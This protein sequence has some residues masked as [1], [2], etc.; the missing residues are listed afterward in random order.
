MLS[1][2]LLEFWICMCHGLSSLRVSVTTL[3]SVGFIS[4]ISMILD[5]SVMQQCYDEVEREGNVTCHTVPLIFLG[6]SGVGK[7][8]LS[9]TLRDSPPPKASGPPKTIAL[10]E[11]RVEVSYVDMKW[12][13]NVGYF[14]EY[15]KGGEYMRALLYSVAATIS[16]MTA[17][18]KDTFKS[19]HLKITL[20]QMLL[21][22]C[23]L[24]SISY[25]KLSPRFIVLLILCT[26]FY[27]L[28]NPSHKIYFVL[29]YGTTFTILLSHFIL[30][31]AH[32]A[33]STLQESLVFLLKVLVYIFYCT[34]LLGLGMGSGLSLAFCF[35]S[36]D[37][38]AK[39][40]EPFVY[41]LFFV[42][43]SHSATLV[44][45]AKM[46]RSI[47]HVLVVCVT[48]LFMTRIY[49][50]IFYCSLGFIVGYF[51]IIFM[52]YGRIL[53]PWMGSGVSRS[54][55]ATTAIGF[56][57]GCPLA[58]LL[59][60][61]LTMDAW[62]FGSSLGGVAFVIFMLS[63]YYKKVRSQAQQVK[64]LQ[65]LLD[66]SA[67]PRK[68]ARIA[69][70]DFAGDEAYREPQKIYMTTFAL[71]IIVFKATDIDRDSTGRNSAIY[72]NICS[73]LNSISSLN[74]QQTKVY[75]VATHKATHFCPIEERVRRIKRLEKRLIRNYKQMLMH[76]PIS[77]G[78]RTRWI[79]QIEN[80]KRQE[81]D[82]DLH[83]LKQ[84]IVDN[85]STENKPLVWFH[86]LDIIRSKD[87]NQ[88]LDSVI[89]PF[90]QLYEHVSRK[91][92][93]RNK[94]EFTEMLQ[95]FSNCGEI[96]YDKRDAALSS[97][98][99]LDRSIL[100]N[101]IRRLIV[102]DPFIE[103]TKLKQCLGDL[104]PN[105][106]YS[107]VVRF[108]EC[109]NFISRMDGA[110]R[111]CYMIPFNLRKK[112][113]SDV[114]STP[115]NLV[116][117]AEF[118]FNAPYHPTSFFLRILCLCQRLETR[119]AES[120]STEFSSRSQ[121]LHSNFGRFIH[122][123]LRYSIVLHR[124]ILVRIWSDEHSVTSTRMQHAATL[125]HQLRCL[126]HHV[127]TFH[128]ENLP[129]SLRL[130]CLQCKRAHTFPPPSPNRFR[131][132]HSR[133]CGC[134]SFLLPSAEEPSL[135]ELQLS[136]NC[137]SFQFASDAHFLRHEST[138]FPIEASVKRQLQQGRR[139]PL[140]VT[141][142]GCGLSDEEKLT[143][144]R[145]VFVL[146]TPGMADGCPKC[147]LRIEKVWKRYAQSTEKCDVT[148]IPVLMAPGLRVP[149]L[150]RNLN[151]VQ[152]ETDDGRM[153][154]NLRRTLTKMRKS[155]AKM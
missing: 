109:L 98:I 150:L 137:V 100:V 67:S 16:G 111:S 81:N 132:L 75:L 18:R 136:H 66:S 21:Y 53:S 42:L 82:E 138:A 114:E 83:L 64:P 17:R 34:M 56:L 152:L 80:L 146:L 20:L 121:Q 11:T 30:T 37:N 33:S 88:K 143:E 145:G 151:P 77:D 120:L 26:G 97:F 5:D 29:A 46:P 23:I 2:K 28:I 47:S 4:D 12:R 41:V 15:L 130:F 43:S 155:W 90:D 79:F 55:L 71:Y 39:F 35:F 14:D 135:Q 107:R 61:S 131:R 113:C 74:F 40:N 103:C 7:T 57:A 45:L 92:E 69:L 99:L 59:G 144:A 38:A 73:W 102:Q 10:E 48:I 8:S 116:A 93:L 78:S 32:D 87:A 94:E 96:F 133:R 91:C 51:Y 124:T 76:V 134:G 44:H 115:R 9:L 105:V 3:W 108:L 128:F 86:F 25:F 68:P 147:K 31:E 65:T 101:I 106:D 95:Y 122:G 149:D 27:W 89:L 126:V 60:C 110:G 36:P 142:S 13:K 52:E 123:K 119:S 24:G 127:S 22:I 118:E 50:L 62:S 117:S 1:S 154:T 129:Y 49:P 72:R 63:G 85:S 141:A 84:S 104:V 70:I 19:G 112:Q 54:V 153:P 58:F 148:L 125:L 6:N 140:T 139:R